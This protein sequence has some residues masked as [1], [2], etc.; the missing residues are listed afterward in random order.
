[1]KKLLSHT[2][3]CCLR[4]TVR[5]VSYYTSVT[6]FLF[7]QSKIDM[8]DTQKFPPSQFIFIK[9]SYLHSEWHADDRLTVSRRQADRQPS[10]G[11]LLADC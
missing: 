5:Y 10:T 1:M 11:R 8:L 9:S 2:C 6:P 4:K 3:A 7:I